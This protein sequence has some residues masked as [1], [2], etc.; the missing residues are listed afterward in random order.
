MNWGRIAVGG[1]MAGLLWTLLSI[2]VLG[3]AGRE[4]TSALLG[5][6]SGPGGR[7]QAFMFL[8]N[9]AHALWGTWL[10]AALRAHYGSGLKTGAIAGVAWWIVVSLQSVK[11]LALSRI[12]AGSVLVLGVLTL[13]AIMIAAMVGGWCY[14][15]FRLHRARD[16]G[17]KA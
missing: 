4:L 9:M 16:Q 13:P 2:L 5:G 6:A 3:V 14:E 8:A 11:W 15:N 12:P 1:F 10:Y 7:I 17:A